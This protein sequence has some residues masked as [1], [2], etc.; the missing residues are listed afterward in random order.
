MN[1]KYEL[2]KTNR[3]SQCDCPLEPLIWPFKVM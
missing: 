1:S 2:L 3:A